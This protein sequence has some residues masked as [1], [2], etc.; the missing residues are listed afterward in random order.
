MQGLNQSLQKKSLNISAMEA[1]FAIIFLSTNREFGVFG[2]GFQF[3]T[4]FI[5]FQVFLKSF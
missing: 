1:L 3:K 5:P 2:F 4:D